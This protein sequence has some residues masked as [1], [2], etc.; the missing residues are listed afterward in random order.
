MSAHW[1]KKKRARCKK[2]NKRWKRKDKKRKRVKRVV[3]TRFVYF[4][5]GKII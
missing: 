3:V 2:K 5:G 1:E 4:Q